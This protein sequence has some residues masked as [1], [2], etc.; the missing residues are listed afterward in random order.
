MINFKNLID[1][2]DFE[3]VWKEYLTF[4]PDMLHLKEDIQV[5]SVPFYIKNQKKTLKT[6]LSI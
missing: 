3:L 6:W 2:V 1:K 4:Y 5:Y